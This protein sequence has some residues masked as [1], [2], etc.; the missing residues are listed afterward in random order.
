[1]VASK[2]M[3]QLSELV[4]EKT[5]NQEQLCVILKAYT[6]KY[7]CKVYK[8]IFDEKHRTSKTL[9][10]F[11]KA[12]REIAVWD[13]DKQ[14]HEYKKFLKWCMKKYDITE[15]DLQTIIE[16]TMMFSIQILLYRYDPQLIDDEVRY[17]GTEPRDVLYSCMKRV[18]RYFYENP[19]DIEEKEN[20][21][22]ELIESS[23]HTF[24][25]MKQ[26]MNIIQETNRDEKV[27]KCDSYDIDN[28]SESSVIDKKTQLIVEKSE[29]AE[30]DLK[31]VSSDEV[32][33]EYYYSEDDLEQKQSTNTDDVKHINIK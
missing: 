33:N 29:E 27:S 22:H 24:I 14:K 19:K 20:D 10:M 6:S 18:A 28:T 15:I 26:I 17:Y 23:I 3:S 7:I 11:Q 2:A 1:M 25:P 12:L 5:K 4:K 32:Y 9:R 16:K 30:D 8:R 13:I 31:Y 21:L